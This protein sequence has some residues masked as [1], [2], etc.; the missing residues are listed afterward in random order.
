MTKREYRGR[1]RERKTR[2]QR[3]YRKRNRAAGK[4]AGERVF[5]AGGWR[6]IVRQFLPLLRSR[7]QKLA[8]PRWS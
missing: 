3:M 6:G 1:Y 5:V 8:R 4:T 7:R 2:L